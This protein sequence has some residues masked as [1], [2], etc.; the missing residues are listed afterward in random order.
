MLSIGVV[1]LM[2]RQIADLSS[3][4][5]L[6]RVECLELAKGK[7]A[8]HGLSRFGDSHD[9]II[10]VEKM[11]PT[12]AMKT[13]PAKK[14][15]VAHGGLGSVVSCIESLEAVLRE[16]TVTV[17]HI[18]SHPVKVKP[19]MEAPTSTPAPQAPAK[20]AGEV[21]VN[22]PGSDGVQDYRILEAAVKGDVVR[23]ARPAEITLKTWRQRIATMRTFYKKTFGVVTKAR[24]E[25]N[26]VDIEVIELNRVK[27]L[28]DAP[29]DAPA[30]APAVQEDTLPP[31][32]AV[33]YSDAEKAFWRDVFL[34]ALK[35][36]S[37]QPDDMA[38]VALAKYRKRFA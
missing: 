17:N 12:W 19:A 25:T 11:V 29:G 30:A 6:S 32:P 26:H 3:R 34:M 28:P 20:P 7:R 37:I 13:I 38:D 2:P 22:Y 18:P 1:G 10:L 14:R 36:G 21:L 16:T 4:T 33:A 24:F 9:C 8:E 31:E 27:L 15:M 23:F 35:L 5:F